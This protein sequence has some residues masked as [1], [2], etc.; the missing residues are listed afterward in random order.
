MMQTLNVWFDLF[1]QM[2]NE[3]FKLQ[4]SRQKFVIHNLKIKFKINIQNS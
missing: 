1:L 4:Y 3:K 2:Q